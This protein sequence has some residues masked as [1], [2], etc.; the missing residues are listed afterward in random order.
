MSP[1]P[2]GLWRQLIWL[3][4][5]D[6]CGSKCWQR[7]RSSLLKVAACSPPVS[8]ALSILSSSSYQQ[9]K[10]SSRPLLLWTHSSCSLIPIPT[11]CLSIHLP[12]RY[13]GHLPLPIVH[14]SCRLLPWVYSVCSPSPCHTCYCNTIL[15]RRLIHILHLRLHLSV[16]H[17]DLAFLL[18]S[19]ASTASQLG[20]VTEEN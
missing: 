9:L 15:Y 16:L 18:L 12:L 14:W 5:P 4:C 6:S 7:C 1:S 3:T 11:P 20:C 13:Q 8:T 10:G 17:C 19:L 2:S